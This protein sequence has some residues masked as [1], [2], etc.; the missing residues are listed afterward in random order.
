MSFSRGLRIAPFARGYLARMRRG[1]ESV[2][3]HLRSPR[4][5]NLPMPTFV[6]LRVTNLCNLRCKMCGQ[7]GDTGIYRTDGFPLSATDGETERNRIK[8]LIGL[9]RQ[10]SLSDYVRLLDE[11]APWKPIVSLFGGEPFLY[12]EIMPLIA[13]VKKRGLTC[14]IITNGGRLAQNARD[15]VEIGIDSIAVSIDGPPQVHDRIRGQAGSFARAAA[16]VRAVAEWRRKLDRTLPMQL[17]I[18]PITELNLEAIGPAVEALRSLPLDTINVGLRWFIPK[19]VGA[20]YEEVI[21]RLSVSP[22][23]PG[24]AS[25]SMEK[26]SWRA[27]LSKRWS[28]S[29]C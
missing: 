26:R 15:L 18:L 6:Q 9:K 16:G 21:R 29:S 11:I 10:L 2:M 5:D 14:T 17:A 13:E 3:G 27:R 25:T 12:P 8:E 24:R 1:R 7:W 20:K 4:P 22:R 19:E 28:S 23:V